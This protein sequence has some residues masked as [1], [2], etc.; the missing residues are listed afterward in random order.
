[1][2]AKVKIVLNEKKDVLAVP[3]DSIITDEDEKSHVLLAVKG[4]DGVTKA[5]SVIVEKGME[6]TY[7]TE[8]TSSE[9][10]EGDMIV[11]NPNNYQDGDVLPISD[12]DTAVQGNGADSDA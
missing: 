5:K 8:I 7:Y 2:N 10:K 12:I 4:A 11:M 1:M 9:I 6:G 3:Y